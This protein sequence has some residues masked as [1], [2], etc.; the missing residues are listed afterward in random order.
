MPVSF[1]GR[2]LASVALALGATVLTTTVALATPPGATPQPGDDRATA[3]AGNVTTCAEAGLTG[4]TTLDSLGTADATNTYVTITAADIPTGDTLVDVVVKGGPAYNVYQG[5]TAWTLLHAPINPGGQI[6][7]I[8]HWFACVTS[9]ANGGGGGGTTTTCPPTGSAAPT[10]TKAVTGSGGTTTNG[11]TAGGSSSTT[12]HVA[13]AAGTT[14]TPGATT[15]LAS[16]GFADS[17][18]VWVGALLLLVG[19]GALLL[20]RTAHR[21]S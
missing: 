13:A 3:H 7:T 18:L 5:L 21:R 1:T 17:W 15:N 11:S 14:A 8:S 20:T 19:A 10:T 9:K 6:P 16:T 4:T 12:A 2:L